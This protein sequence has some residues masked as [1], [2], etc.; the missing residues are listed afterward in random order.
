MTEP[1]TE[2]PSETEGAE[3][4]NRPASGERD[5]TTGKFLP[6]HSGN[7]VGRPQSDREFQETLRKKYGPRVVRA[8]LKFMR[9]K[10]ER[11]AFM[12]TQY[13]CD[14][15]Y[16]KPAQAITGAGG[17]P[18]GP[19]VAVGINAPIGDMSPAEVYAA[20]VRDV[21]FRLPPGFVQRE[22]LP[23]P[24]AAA[25]AVEAIIE[26]PLEQHAAPEPASPADVEQPAPVDPIEARIAPIEDKTVAQW[27]R[28]AD[29][30]APAAPAPKETATEKR[31]REMREWN[32]AERLRQ[33]EAGRIRAARA[34]GES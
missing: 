13:M 18:L 2:Q 20:M 12:A 24:A 5:P 7:K 4:A 9:S 29:E 3:P 6:G 17:A 26:Q 16:G 23:L 31:R 30:P 32:E 21:G 8:M 10:N 22:A 27:A 34:R 33:A 25:E 14:R 15:L 19:L 11:V 1:H 28:L